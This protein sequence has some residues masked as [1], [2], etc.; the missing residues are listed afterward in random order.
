MSFLNYYI[1]FEN[2]IGEGEDVEI[3]IQDLATLDDPPGPTVEIELEGKD[4]AVL[5]DS[6]TNEDNKTE[7]IKGRRLTFGFNSG[8]YDVDGVDTVVDVGTF[9]DGD[10]GRFRVRLGTGTGPLAVPFLGNLVLDD[11]SEAFQPRPNAVQLRAGEGFGNLKEIEFKDGDQ[12]AIGHY[13]IID[14]FVMIL[15]RLVTGQDIHVVFNLYE[16]D[17]D[18]EASHA[19]SD[20]Y[21]NALTFETDVDKREDCF[22]VLTKI[23]EALG[24]FITNDNDGW[25]IIRWDEY[26][27]IGTSIL[28]HRVANFTNAGVLQNYTLENLTKRIASDQDVLYEG[29]YMSFDSA[30]RRYQRK[31]KSVTHEYKYE[32][33]KE[34]PC[35]SGFTRGQVD[36]DVLPLKTYVPSCWTLKRG[37]GVNETTPNSDMRIWVRYDANDNEDERYLV[38]TPQAASGGEFNYGV[39][40][41]I[42]IHEKDKFEFSVD[43]SADSDNAINGP[44]SIGIAAVVLYG[45][46]STVWI[47]GDNI[48]ALGDVQ[49]PEWKLTNADLSVNFDYYQ[50][51]FDAS[52]GAEDYTEFRTYSIDAPP[53]PV[54][55][56]VKIHL[57]AANQLGSGIDDFA[58]RYNNLQYTYIPLV[59]G[60]YQRVNGQRQQVT[61]DNDSRKEIVHQMYLG[62]SPKK[63]F[64][65][66]LKK[67]DGTNYVLTETWNDFLTATYF[68]DVQ[69]GK[70]IVFQWWNQFRKTRT[71]IE[72]DVQGLNS[73]E[74]TGIPGLIHRWAIQ[75]EGQETKWF[76]LTSFRAMD[77]YKCGWQGVF[78]ETSDLDGDRNYDDTY[79]FSYIYGG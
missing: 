71:V 61:G 13:A 24:C 37:W 31:A 30:Q 47:L 21:I 73:G 50:W 60:T 77:F 56:Q 10:D 41:G 23:C 66:A 32:Q 64:K 69:L 6:V 67:F 12:I 43:Y 26:D 46:D 14:Y 17:T 18:P 8:E 29:Y 45:D 75:H 11:N 55:G 22:T 38:F 19:F 52:S 58:I 54:D 74:A 49:V 33:P 1:R 39:S 51:F 79:L 25:W 7:A 4:I 28:T 78:V 57:F 53:A 2:F 20:T 3:Q 70:F 76:M 15:D 62:D 42:D 48:S 27:A 9:S 35:N 5:M 44:A 63:L 59:G 65:G 36:D 16:T 68:T 40:E 34:V 72:T